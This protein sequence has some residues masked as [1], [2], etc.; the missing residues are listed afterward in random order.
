MLVSGCSFTAGYGFDQEKNNPRFWTNQLSKKL[1]VHDVCNTAITGV[2][3]RVIFFNTM[4]E[5][6]NNRYDLVIVQWSA[7]P[8]F[9]FN[10]GLELY[11]TYTRLLKPH[12]M[13]LVNNQTIPESWFKKI[14]DD[15]LKIHHDHWD[16]LELVTYVNTLREI[17]VVNRKSKLF[18]VNGLGPW[19]DNFFQKKTLN[20]PSDLDSYTAGLLDIDLRDDEEIFLLYDKIHNDY[21]SVG[22]IRPELW[23]NLYQS[24]DRIKLDT[25]HPKDG[26][27][28]YLSQDLY[29][30]MFCNSIHAG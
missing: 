2:N 19:S 23:L 11:S 10:V 22:G 6:L 13:R 20:L 5:L 18:F 14:G 8:R 15:L 26:H 16:I 4:T 25:V 21:E 12:P 7:I 29:A 28:G 30:D 24:M 27:P 17:Q 1:Q 9:G 3:N